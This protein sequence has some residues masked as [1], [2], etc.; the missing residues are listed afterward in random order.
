MSAPS[1]RGFIKDL[2]SGLSGICVIINCNKSHCE[3]TDIAFGLS[4]LKENR[5]F[6]EESR[7]AGAA[8]GGGAAEGGALDLWLYL[9]VKGRQTSFLMSLQCCVGGRLMWGP[10]GSWPPASACSPLFLLPSPHWSLGAKQQL[11]WQSSGS[12]SHSE[13]IQAGMNMK[14]K[15]PEHVEDSAGLSLQQWPEPHHLTRPS[16]RGTWPPHTSG[17]VSCGMSPSEED[18][19]HLLST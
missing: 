4:W 14:D 12:V 15:M 13:G 6:P 8:V 11:Y 18:T 10:K 19:G 1:P 2:F 7:R 17:S 3:G 16:L 9:S 5:D